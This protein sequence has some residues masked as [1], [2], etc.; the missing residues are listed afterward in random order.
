MVGLH[1]LQ[2]CRQRA[3]TKRWHRI[4]NKDVCCVLTGEFESMVQPVDTREA[5]L[6]SCLQVKLP[7][8]TK[9]SLSF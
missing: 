8:K 9:Y 7:V 1:K 4:K 2:V 6:P 3:S 5:G